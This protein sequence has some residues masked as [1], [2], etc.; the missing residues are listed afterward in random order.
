MRKGWQMRLCGKLKIFFLAAALLWAAVSSFPEGPSPARAARKPERL[1]AMLLALA[2]RERI[3]GLHKLAGDPGYSN[4]AGKVGE[5]PLIGSAP[6]R[7]ISFRPD[8]VFVASYSSA[9]F[10]NHLRAAGAPVSKFSAFSGME[11]VFA[12]I[13]KMGRLIGEEDKAQKLIQD[14]KERIHAIRSRIPKN[15]RP[16]RILTLVRGGWVTGGGTS[17][18]ALIRLAGG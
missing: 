18:D 5:I 6:E 17:H 11:D 14:A 12:S 4:V 9:A 1:I 15:A 16:P 2:P 13:E 8:M 3:V 7:I 10:L